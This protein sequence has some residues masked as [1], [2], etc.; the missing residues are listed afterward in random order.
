MM[1]AYKDMSRDE[2][3]A[4][5]RSLEEEYKTEKGKKRKNQKKKGRGV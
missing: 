2:L 4:L 3:L 5:K 1:K